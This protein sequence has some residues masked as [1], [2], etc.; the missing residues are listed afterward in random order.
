MAVVVKVFLASPS[1]VNAERKVVRERAEHFNRLWSDHF[2]I[3]LKVI[4]WEDLPPTAQRPQQRINAD[5]DECL[6]F[7]GLL[8]ERWG[9]NSGEFSS[10]FEEEFVLANRRRQQTASPGIALFF[11]ALDSS[12]IGDPGPQLSKVLEF[13]QT[14]LDGREFL[15]KEFAT[16]EEL[17]NSIDGVFSQFARDRQASSEQ[18][19][20]S[21]RTAKKTEASPTEGSAD[22]RFLPS[23]FAATHEAGSEGAATKLDLWGRLRLWLYA[24]S[25]LVETQ[26]DVN[27]G[28]HQANLIYIRRKA[29]ELAASERD[30][31]I[32]AML[33]DQHGYTPGWYWLMQDDVRLVRLHLWFLC[34]NDE[35]AKSSA[36]KILEHDDVLPSESIQISAALN[37][38]TTAPSILKLLTRIGSEEH[39]A[40]V[41]EA[42]AGASK[43]HSFEAAEFALRRRTGH[44]FSIWELAAAVDNWISE[45]MPLLVE[46]VQELDGPGLEALLHGTG[47]G[48]IARELARAG[49]L[50]PETAL[51][52]IADENADVREAAVRT[53]IANGH[54]FIRDRLESLF[55][56]E[57]NGTLLGLMR[58]PDIGG[59]VK[60]GLPSLP[61]DN[62]KTMVDFFNI[63]GAAAFSVLAE[64]HWDWFAT[65]V[66]RELNNEFQPLIEE[67]DARSKR[68][69]GVSALAVWKDDLLEYKRAQFLEGALSAVRKHGHEKATEWARKYSN[70]KY[71]DNVRTEALMLQLVTAGNIDFGPMLDEFER[72]PTRFATAA[73]ETVLS[74]VKLSPKLIEKIAAHESVEVRTGL[75]R[76][77]IAHWTIEF[78]NSLTPLLASES[79]VV[80]KLA[81]ATLADRFERDE[82]ESLLDWYTSR[83]RYYYDVVT[84]FDIAVYAPAPYREH[85]LAVR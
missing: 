65:E 77:L 79:D 74:T 78:A 40:L 3:H 2:G 15:Y 41:I 16:P 64:N 12:R 85:L 44:K 9:S 47:G 13:K 68:Q 53:A 57:S 50:P 73:L 72:L 18:A 27:I 76:W 31:V 33:R 42:K 49:Q 6:L 55:T 37:D 83:D 14:I 19:H 80:R 23:I 56:K 59:M 24:S 60:D 70:A 71:R 46:R 82:L 26:D 25:L 22:A 43:P 36:A 69:H 1:D 10:G 63:D 67:S 58:A 35:S 54:V 39:L 75:Q 52:L 38:E 51:R 30:L 84:L 81:A 61:I 8:A 21:N 17:S 29:W 7:I 45:A 4:G 20:E 34:C 62:V 11:K 66:E 5:A 32:R 28:T 48:R